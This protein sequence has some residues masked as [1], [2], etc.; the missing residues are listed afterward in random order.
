MANHSTRPCP[1]C[2]NTQLS[3][4]A[5]YSKDEW[6]IVQCVDCDLVFLENPVDIE[7]ARFDYKLVNRANL[8]L[9]DNIKALIEKP[10]QSEQGEVA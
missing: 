4:L 3:N 6:A 8:W 2:A 1:N 5:A 10:M 7:P 9:D